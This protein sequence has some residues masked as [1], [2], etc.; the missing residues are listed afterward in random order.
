MHSY[1]CHMW[2]AGCVVL[3]ANITCLYRNKRLQVTCLGCPSSYRSKWRQLEAPNNQQLTYRYDTCKNANN[4]VQLY[5][6]HCQTIRPKLRWVSDC[7][8]AAGNCW[9]ISR[10]QCGKNKQ[11]SMCP[12]PSFTQHNI[13]YAAHLVVISGTLILS[14]YHITWGIYSSTGWKT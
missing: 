5:Q 11:S 10:A 4:S 7:A 2:A 14:H 12:P 8:K 9:K 3:P 13:V 1:V 6:K